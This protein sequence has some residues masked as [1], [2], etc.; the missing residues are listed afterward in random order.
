[1]FAR[2]GSSEARLASLYVLFWVVVLVLGSWFL[3]M[4]TR[5]ARL[6]A[7]LASL[8]FIKSELWE[9]E[10]SLSEAGARLY[11]LSLIEL[12]FAFLLR[13]RCWDLFLRFLGFCFDLN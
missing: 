12:Q 11:S 3:G 5:L 9:L 8:M 13:I 10:S 6:K 2:L 1:R 4:N 7:R